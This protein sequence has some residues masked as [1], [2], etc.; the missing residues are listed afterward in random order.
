MLSV[1]L[2]VGL[3]SPTMRVKAV[4]LNF[5]DVLNVLGMY[6]GDPGPPGGDCAG[7]VCAGG[8]MQMQ[9]V[10]GLSFGSLR[11]YTPTDPQLLVRIPTQWS[12][13]EASA[14][15]TTWVTAWMCLE[16]P[17]VMNAGQHGLIQAATGGVG[18]VAVELLQRGGVR[19][20]ATAGRDKKQ[21]YLRR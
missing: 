11:S 1:H 10:V 14:M 15:P 5:R 4:G 6:P 2:Q 3:R 20:V 17:G 19:V 16:E 7:D 8:G 18:L 9:A 13:S 12:Y 21:G